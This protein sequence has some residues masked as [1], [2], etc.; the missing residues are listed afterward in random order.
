MADLT[1][2][3]AATPEAAYVVT[4]DRT[5]PDLDATG[6]SGGEVV[7][8]V[9]RRGGCPGG[10]AVE[11]TVPEQDARPVGLGRFHLER[12]AVTPGMIGRAYQP[13][14]ADVEPDSRQR[15]KGYLQPDSLTLRNL[16]GA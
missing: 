14:H 6:E 9:A 10:T 13:W 1:L 7:E 3:Y 16:I 4:R 11:I 15:W 8:L 5:L 2:F 12:D